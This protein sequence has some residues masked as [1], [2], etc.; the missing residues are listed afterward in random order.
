MI[1]GSITVVS[2]ATGT[3]S[4]SGHQ[5]SHNQCPLHDSHAEVLAK[6][7][8]Q[9]FLYA[10]LSKELSNNTLLSNNETF[11]FVQKANEKR[12]ITIKP[13]YK[14]HLVI[15]HCPCGDCATSKPDATI[16]EIASTGAKP[17]KDFKSK[18]V[19]VHLASKTGILRTK[20]YRSDTPIANRSCSLSC[21]DK[22][23]LWNILGIQGALLSH[24][25]SPIY[26]DNIHVIEKVDLDCFTRGI[27]LKE[28]KIG[29]NIE[30]NIFQ[31][32][33]KII[34]KLYRVEIRLN[35][36]KFDR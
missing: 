3:K 12:I 1:G 28:R 17:L 35:N 25:I 6:R 29:K 33:N 8:F 2:L 15:S 23:M 20:P 16:Q 18:M 26:I 13:H 36:S 24:F 10:Q 11:F 34:S 4:L 30:E 7:G 5:F 21:S 9:A 22:I 27:N 31:W 14:I 19:S 32:E